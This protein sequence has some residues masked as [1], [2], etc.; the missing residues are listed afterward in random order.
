MLA[1]GAGAAL[2]S[3]RASGAAAVAGV[4]AV[5]IESTA[6]AAM[7]CARSGAAKHT[8]NATRA[9]PDKRDIIIS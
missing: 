9:K 2:L 3:M 5:A 7:V 4:V 1:L 8:N 6:V